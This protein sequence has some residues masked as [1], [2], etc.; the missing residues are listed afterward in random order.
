MSISASYIFEAV[1][2]A[3][4]WLGVVSTS[5]LFC[6]LKHFLNCF[7][8]VGEQVG[9]VPLGVFTVPGL[10]ACIFLMAMGSC[11][12]L[13]EVDEPGCQLWLRAVVVRLQRLG[14]VESARRRP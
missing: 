13:P 9:L 5:K 12:L 10:L 8:L 2:A 4:C 11:C 3:A 14:E 7:G 6:R 1:R